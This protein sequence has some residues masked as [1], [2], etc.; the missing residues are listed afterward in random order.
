MPEQKIICPQCQNTI[1][2]GNDHCNICGFDYI[3]YLKEKKRP[4]STNRNLS[5]IFVSLFFLIFA[6]FI[7]TFNLYLPKLLSSASSQDIFT[8]L[9][10]LPYIIPG[11]AITIIIFSFLTIALT[12]NKKNK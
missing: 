4:A 10:L 6:G 5:A 8:F 12:K 2:E 11:I 9:K 3:Q 1:P 7:L